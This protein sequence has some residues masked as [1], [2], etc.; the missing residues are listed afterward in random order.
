MYKDGFFE[1][2]IQ[3]NL[4]VFDAVFSQKLKKTAEVVLYATQLSGPWHL[5]GQGI[6][7]LIKFLFLFGFQNV[8]NLLQACQELYHSKNF[9]LVL[10]YVLSVGNILNAGSNRGGA[11]G[12]KLQS[13]PKVT[14]DVN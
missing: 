14:T 9:L 1:S 3:Y 5:K 6:L 7:F 2:F 11:Y 13:L 12:F 4:E 10:E 8:N